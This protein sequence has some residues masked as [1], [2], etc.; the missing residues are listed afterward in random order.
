VTRATI[1]AAENNE[2][3]RRRGDLTVWV[4]D[5]VAKMWSSPRRKTQGGWALYSDLAI[6]I[7]MTLR[8]VFR[9]LLRQTQRFTYMSQA[10]D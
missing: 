4:A 5:D 2:S 3:L 7:C 8:V 6:E 9:L 1:N 10:V